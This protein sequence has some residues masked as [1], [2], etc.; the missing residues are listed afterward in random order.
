MHGIL[1][2]KPFLYNTNRKL[3]PGLI[4]TAIKVCTGR[5]W[6]FACTEDIPDAV[7]LVGWIEN[8]ITSKVLSVADAVR[9]WKSLVVSC[10]TNSHDVLLRQD[11]WDDT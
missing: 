1:M 4:D 10:D 7:A 3:R 11:Q 5:P 2:Y 6:K 8:F 9:K